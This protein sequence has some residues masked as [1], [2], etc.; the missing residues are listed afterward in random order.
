MRFKAGVADILKGRISLYNVFFTADM[1]EFIRNHE[2]EEI[3]V[4]VV[5][6]RYSVIHKDIPAYLIWPRE[7]F[8]KQLEVI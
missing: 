7:I 1:K 8:T 2:D 6:R 5:A 4:Q 3:E